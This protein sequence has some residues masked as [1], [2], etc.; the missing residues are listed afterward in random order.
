VKTASDAAR[1]EEAIEGA[2]AAHDVRRAEADASAYLEWAARRDGAADPGRSPSV[3]AA[4]LA[5]QVSLAGGRPAEAAGRLVPV[6]GVVPRLP[7]PLAC[8]V[9]LLA[10]EAHARRGGAEAEARRHL[11]GARQLVGRPED[12]PL[13]W[14]RELR[15]R[16]W[17]GEVRALAEELARCGRRLEADP[18][19]R[20]LLLCEEGRA[21]DREGES[22]RAE[23]CWG[24]ARDAAA[25]LGVHPVRADVL[26][27]LGRLEHLRGHFQ[28][29]L[30]LY[31]AA[32]QAAPSGGGQAA[33]ALLRRARVLL[34]LGQ[35]DA[36]A[37]LF[38]AAL[39]GRPPAGVPEELRGLAEETG[40]LL[41]DGGEHAASAEERAYRLAQGGD[42]A[43]AR[44]LYAEIA[45]GAAAERKARAMLHLGL[46]A[47][48]D[49]DRAEAGSHLAAAT[50]LARA[51]RLPEVLWR[52][53]E[54]Q[55]TLA[56]EVD[57]D[58][59]RARGFFE[60]AV[61]VASAQ[62]GRLA[63]PAAGKLYGLARAGAVRLLLRG[64]CRRGDAAATFAYQELERGRLLLD[65][66]RSAV[67]PAGRP[68][69]ADLPDLTDVDRRLGE[70]EALLERRE[71][72]RRRCAE[73]RAERDALLRQLLAGPPGEEDADRLR[74][75]QASL[76]A[77]EG[78]LQAVEASLGD[79]FWQERRELLG[80]RDRVLEAYLRDRGRPGGAAAPPLPGLD[81]LQRRLPPGSVYLAPALVEDEVYLLVAR[82]G[83]PGRVVR[84]P[85]PADAV[86]AAVRDFRACLEAQL[87]RYRLGWQM[88]EPERRDLDASLE[89]LGASPLGAALADTL[90]GCRD[91]LVWVPDAG[92]SG[93][94]VHALRRGGR[95]L[96]EDHEVA[97]AVSGA[98]LVHQAGAPRRRRWG[99]ALVVTES[100]DV[101]PTAPAEGAAV[102]AAFWRSRPLH[103]AA[104]TR[105]ALRRRLGR[106]RVVHFA[107]HG[108]LDG[109]HPLAAF[110]RLPSG[111][112]LRA[113]DWLDE[114]ADGLPLVNFSACHSGE[115]AGL[116]GGEVFGLTVGALAG[117]VRAVLAALWPVP[118]EEAAPFMGRFYR[119]RLTND[120]A[121]ALALAQRDAIAAGE[122]PLGWAVFALFGD[123]AALPP[124]PPWLRWWARWRQRWH[125][126][127][128]PTRRPRGQG[129][130]P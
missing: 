127:L 67:T 9:R 76:A 61:A 58:D 15:V 43:A 90:A 1:F 121:G 52:A 91:R 87:R 55:G 119:H 73:L 3:R 103:G 59:D 105:A 4:Y 114:P 8:R 69:L 107:C 122:S 60:E 40:R 113:L 33:E 56:A 20:A 94:P 84:A 39:E 48:A 5:A 120:L 17:L 85:G 22:A 34:D 80:R 129:D 64:A 71:R 74:G 7:A 128:F 97:Q 54:G 37:D 108:H 30:D 62:A 101:L 96:V 32:G 45:A 92:L 95:Y 16:L 41:G 106:A 24:R 66:W 99:P 51:L 124:A 126:R 117:G 72:L 111:E 44:R 12:A 63:D 46:L 88:G 112:A 81:E 29:A 10:A 115:A 123:P 47:L 118:D 89:R 38:A 57:G 25:G 23:A 26:V 6:L 93:V 27:Q 53:L 18:A 104:A 83:T 11:A 28:P 68:A 109:D 50:S 86:R 13:L 116:V 65:L 35:A 100:A 75:P 102:A 21:W 79:G 110:V 19:N 125:E 49:R 14:L 82:P 98:L 42:R 78:E 130:R 70:Q 36:A 77:A 2:L 31:A